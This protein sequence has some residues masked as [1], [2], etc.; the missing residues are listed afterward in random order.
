MFTYSITF[1][2]VE[3]NLIPR[4]RD[5]LTTHRVSLIVELLYFTHIIVSQS[6]T[7]RR[8]KN[9][10]DHSYLKSVVSRVGNLTR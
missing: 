5:L 6:S 8:M 2:F 4:G 10:Q 9:Y 1:D 7:T 3:I